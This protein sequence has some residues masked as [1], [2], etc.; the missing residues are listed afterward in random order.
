S[1][2]DYDSGLSAGFAYSATEGEIY[3]LGSKEEYYT[4]DSTNPIK[5]YTDGLNSVHL[6][7]EGV[8][9]FVSS[10]T[11]S[12]KDGLKLHVDVLPREISKGNDRIATTVLD[13]DSDSDAV[14]APGPVTPSGSAR[15]GVSMVLVVAGFGLWFV[16][17]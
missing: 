2:V 8:R 17:L 13:S 16:G 12:C 9:Y 15:V 4:C 5:M 7:G 1:R 10:N 3:E 14:R 6:T 11:S